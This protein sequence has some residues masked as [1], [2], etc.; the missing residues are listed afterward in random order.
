MEGRVKWTRL[1]PGE[2]P[3]EI[4]RDTLHVKARGTL[5][6]DGTDTI[7]ISFLHLDWVDI[8]EISLHRTRTPAEYVD[9]VEEYSK[10]MMPRTTRYVPFA[11]DQLFL[12]LVWLRLNLQ[13]VF[14]SE[15][16]VHIA[17]YLVYE[18]REC[19]VCDQWMAQGEMLDWD[20]ARC[21]KCVKRK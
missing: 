21:K 5:H 18:V 14:P 6:E 3:G 7:R 8:H 13:D 15:V 19:I 16:F 20:F 2:N 17:S 11:R 1:A 12:R 10:R 9:Y 4:T